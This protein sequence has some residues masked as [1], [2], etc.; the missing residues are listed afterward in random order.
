M[1][2]AAWFIPCGLGSGQAAELCG[3]SLLSRLR[4]PL[5]ASSTC[6]S[7]LLRGR[8]RATSGGRDD[9]GPCYGVD[10]DEETFEVGVG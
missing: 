8:E 1:S 3:R 5:E 10:T 6:R 7:W 2:V 4:S 9:G